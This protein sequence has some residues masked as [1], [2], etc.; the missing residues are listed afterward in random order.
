MFRWPLAAAALFIAALPAPAADRPNVLF[1]AIDDL[2][3]WVGYLGDKQA[4][5][6][7]LYDHD[8]D[9]KEW[10]NLAG[11]PKLAG[12]KADLAKWFPKEN[13]PDAGTKKGK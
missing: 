1:I 10:K 7:E 4:R 12:V 3:D 5:D 11:D 6:E 9:P 13:A 2:R 8:A